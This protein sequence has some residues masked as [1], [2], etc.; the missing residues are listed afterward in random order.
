MRGV[1]MISAFDFRETGNRVVDEALRRV[2]EKLEEILK[3]T[4]VQGE[5]IGPFTVANTASNKIPHG[6]GRR[7]RGWLQ[8]Y[9]SAN[10]AIWDAAVPD[11]TYL[12]LGANGSATVRAVVF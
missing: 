4:L 3:A 9:K 10:V 6:L 5:L 7:P 2:K 11:A 12:Y 8:A 1:R